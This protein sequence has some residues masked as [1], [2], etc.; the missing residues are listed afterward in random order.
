MQENDFDIAPQQC[1]AARLR[2]KSFAVQLYANRAEAQSNY[3][4]GKKKR[5]KEAKLTK[6]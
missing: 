4:T 6:V 2:K 1:N 3:N 5:R